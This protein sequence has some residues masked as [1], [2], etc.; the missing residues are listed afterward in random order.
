VE[1]AFGLNIPRTLED[2]CDPTRT[3]LIVY[4]MQVGIVS[5]IPDGQSIIERVATVRQAA[6]GCGMH[7]SGTHRPFRSRPS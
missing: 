5:Q 3:A 4:D 1:H 7:S 6:R 2:L